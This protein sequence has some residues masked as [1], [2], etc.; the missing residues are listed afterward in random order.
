LFEREFRRALT[1]ADGT[2][3]HKLARHLDRFRKPIDPLRSWVATLFYREA[4][5]RG[6]LRKSKQ[7]H[8]VNRKT[9]RELLT[10][11]HAAYP[12]DAG[13]LKKDAEEL[14]AFLRVLREF[15]VKWKKSPVGRRARKARGTR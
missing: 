2:F 5:G 3:F 1:A 8:W 12:K 15:G 6:D 4:N 11:F 10:L 13:E 14:K 9:S 7:H